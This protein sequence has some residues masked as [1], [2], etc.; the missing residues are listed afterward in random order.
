[1]NKAAA[2]KIINLSI[3]INKIKTSL[4]KI[5]KSLELDTAVFFGLLGKLWMLCSGPITALLIATRFSKEIQGYYYTFFN[6]VALQVFVEMGLGTVIQ[7]FASH[8]WAYLKLDNKGYIIGNKDALSRLISITHIAF[9]WYTI[10]ALIVIVGL[11]IGGYLFFADSSQFHV[12][13]KYPWF[14]LALLTGIN[15]IFVPAWSLL[16]GCNQVS[17]LYMYRFFN[18]VISSIFVWFS[19]LLGAHLWTPV[20]SNMATLIFAS[21]FLTGKYLNFFKTLIWEKPS[22]PVISWRLHMLPMQW[23]IALSWMSGYFVFS[24]FTPVLFKF[25]GP[26]VAGQFGMTW[27]I[28][29]LMGA[30]SGSWLSPRVPQLAMLISQKKYDE[31]DRL[32]W[33]ITKIVLWINATTAFVIWFIIYL[34]NTLDYP[35]FTKFASRI[36]SPSTAGILLVGQFL[37]VSSFPFSIYLRAHKKE[38]V[39]PVSVLSAIMVGLSTL[40][41]GKY[42]S[43]MGI[44]TGYLITH[45]IVVPMVFFIWYRKRAEWHSI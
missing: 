18:G 31:L 14:C 25:H 43:V 27:S 4:S 9:K 39:M 41:L 33:K 10:G 16:E 29:G 20:I 44:V 6:I 15:I 32:F 13:W 2:L 11:S 21:I 37:L 35:F 22:G 36:L 40:I 30:I 45:M 19:I 42:Y 17:T 28:V 8:E 3:H 23:R 7:Q 5:Q 24:F 1:M 38:P 26:V 12:D 34:L